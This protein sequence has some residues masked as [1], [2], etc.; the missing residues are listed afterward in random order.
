MLPQDEKKQSTIDAQPDKI[1][2][3]HRALMRRLVSGQTLTEACGDLGFTVS[4]ASIIV[5]SPLFQAEMKQME[6]DVG[7]DFVEAEALK[8]GDATRQVITD[9]TEP[10][11]KTLK[12]SLN[13]ENESIRVTAAKDILDRGGY[14]KEDKLKARVLVEPS[15][16]LID[17]LSRITTEKSVEQPPDG[18]A[19]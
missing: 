1:T 11:A 17:V 12:Q 9:A 3:R 19:D 6:A 15:P 16:A 4:R 14:A 7:R 5:N 18:K 8:S 2:P 13:S 10:A